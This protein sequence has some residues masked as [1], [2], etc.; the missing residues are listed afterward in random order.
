M[1]TAASRLLSN[2]EAAAVL[3]IRPETL[4]RWRSKTYKNRRRIP[5]LRIG[6]LIK[7]REVDLVRWIN[8]C[9]EAA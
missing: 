2:R 7:Y 3:G 1:T 9:E 6:R 5:F 4:K 8:S